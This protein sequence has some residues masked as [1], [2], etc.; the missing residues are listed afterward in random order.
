MKADTKTKSRQ[1]RAKDKVANKN[2]TKYK[3]KI[4]DEG[5]G[6]AWNSLEGGDE[7]VGA[8]WNSPEGGDEDIGVAWNSLES[9]NEGEGAGW[10][11][12]EAALNEIRYI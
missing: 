8:A 2:E 4:N 12:L 3:S 9:G 5:V 1:N 7:G 6:A 11:P 10:N